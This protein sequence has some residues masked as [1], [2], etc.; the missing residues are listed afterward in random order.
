MEPTKLFIFLLI[1]GYRFGNSYEVGDTLFSLKVQTRQVP[2]CNCGVAIKEGLFF[3]VY[4]MCNNQPHLSIGSS[5]LPDSAKDGFYTQKTNLGHITRYKASI[6]SS[7][8]F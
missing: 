6:K 5:T 1:Y 7:R 2:C 4:D 8:T 3:K